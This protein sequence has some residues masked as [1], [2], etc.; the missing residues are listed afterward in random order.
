MSS[1]SKFT[2]FLYRAFLR[3]A[4]KEKIKVAFADSDVLVLKSIIKCDY[5]N[6]KRSAPLSAADYIERLEVIK[7]LTI[8]IPH[9]SR[10]CE[11]TILMYR[12]HEDDIRLHD[13]LLKLS[14]NNFQDEKEDRRRPLNK[15]PT[16][17]SFTEVLDKMLDENKAGTSHIDLLTMFK[18]RLGFA[19]VRRRIEKLASQF[20]EVTRFFDEHYHNL[21]D[22]LPDGIK[23]DFRTTR[24]MLMKFGEELRLAID[25]N[26]KSN[27]SWTYFLFGCWNF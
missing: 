21:D 14:R 6:Q 5:I 15:V 8:D 11:R 25:T 19:A 1:P 23:E 20:D 2:E 7:T 27:L 17:I 12:K 13:Y 4:K 16:V 24:D 10:L 26:T 18:P 3:S 9:F 22:G